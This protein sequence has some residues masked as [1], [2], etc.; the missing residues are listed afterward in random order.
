MANLSRMA[1]A[2][3]VHRRL[4]KDYEFKVQTSETLIDLGF[5]FLGSLPILLVLL[6][7]DVMCLFLILKNSNLTAKLPL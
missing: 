6:V 7:I 2:E 3:R 5:A 4:S 1:S